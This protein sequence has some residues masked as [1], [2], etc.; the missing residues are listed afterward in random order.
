MP[1]TPDATVT[2]EP[3]DSRP[4]ASAAEE[5]RALKAW[6]AANVGFKYVSVYTAPAGAYTLVVADAGRGVRKDDAATVTVPPN[7]SVSFP[8]GTL[9]SGV[10]N[11]NS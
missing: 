5:F 1:Y 4:V 3:L 11:N 8:A 9:I 2:T 6:I 10:N 7:S